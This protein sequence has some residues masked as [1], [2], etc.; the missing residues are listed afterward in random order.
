MGQ[1][2][3]DE[4]KQYIMSLRADPII[5]KAAEEFTASRNEFFPN[6]NLELGR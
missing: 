2:G 5:R 3:M 1:I 4:Y 6:G